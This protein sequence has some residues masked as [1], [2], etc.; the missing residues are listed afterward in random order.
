MEKIVSGR[1]F[2][3]LSDRK[4]ILWMTTGDNSFKIGQVFTFVNGRRKILAEIV[5][6][7]EYCTFESALRN[8]DWSLVPFDADSESTVLD[9]LKRNFSVSRQLHGIIVLE[10]EISSNT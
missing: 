8:E 1:I 3:L 7:R 4:E 9:L 10:L 2:D 6:I 5:K